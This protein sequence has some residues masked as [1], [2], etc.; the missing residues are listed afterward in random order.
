MSNHTK[1]KKTH[2]LRKKNTRPL[3]MSPVTYSQPPAHLSYALTR[4]QLTTKI[5]IHHQ[6]DIPTIL[7]RFRHSTFQ[8]D[9][10]IEAI[11]GNIYTAAKYPV[12]KW[13][14]IWAVR[15]SYP[16]KCIYTF[17]CFCLLNF[18]FVL[19]ILCVVI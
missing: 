2:K 10:Y 19:F 4:R 7:I 6:R 15:Y 12:I 14:R 16:Q 9:L 17:C 3:N 18:G 13:F 8:S 5:I 11:P 1:V